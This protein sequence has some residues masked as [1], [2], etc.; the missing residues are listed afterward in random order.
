MRWG[1][2]ERT[3]VL[4]NEHQE[5]NLLVRV[6]VSSSISVLEYFIHVHYLCGSVYQHTLYWIYITASPI[7]L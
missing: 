4:Y 5:Q 7:I 6:K 2:R 3:D 1:E